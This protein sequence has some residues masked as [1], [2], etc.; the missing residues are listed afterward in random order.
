MPVAGDG[1]AALHRTEQLKRLDADEKG[2]QGWYSNPA[3]VSA[4]VVITP[5]SAPLTEL[6]RLDSRFKLFYEDKLATVFVPATHEPDC[7]N[8]L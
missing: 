2:K 8:S 4:G 3:L 6:L 1:R 7:P 5:R